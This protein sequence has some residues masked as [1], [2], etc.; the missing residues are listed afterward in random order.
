MRMVAILDEA[1]TGIGAAV[2]NVEKNLANAREVFERHLASK[3]VQVGD[4]WV[5]RNLAGVTT[6]IG[7]GATPR[8]GNESYK[9]EGMS[10]IRSLNV[11]DRQFVS[12]KLALIDAAQAMSLSNVTVQSGDVLFNITGASV[13]RCCIVPDAVLPA[14]VNQH[15]AIIRSARDTVTPQFLCYLLTSEPYK[16]RLLDVGEGGSTRQAITK[17]QLQAFRIAFPMSLEEQNAIVAGLDHHRMVVERLESLFQ[18][19]LSVLA[20]LKQ[21]ILQKAFAGKL[22]AREAERELAAA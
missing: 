3:F 1:F 4:N 17:A 10:L 16:K 19:K 13:A 15:V 8:G 7:S 21:S 14:R 11:H 6:K 5:T 20:E 9:T 12:D 2:A 22:T 18:R